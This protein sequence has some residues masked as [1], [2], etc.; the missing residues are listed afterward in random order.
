MRRFA[1]LGERIAAALC[2][3][4]KTCLRHDVSDAILDGEV[5]AADDEG[6][7]QFYD[8]LRHRRVPAYMA[9]DLMWLDGTDL[10]GLC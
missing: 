1:R 6:R 10:R 9:F 3:T 7:P 8:L 5:I 4:S 2:V